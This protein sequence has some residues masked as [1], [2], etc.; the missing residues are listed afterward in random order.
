MKILSRLESGRFASILIL[1]AAVSAVLSLVTDESGL[2]VLF[3]GIAIIAIAVVLVAQIS[4]I[5]KISSIVNNNILKINQRVSIVAAETKDAIE[6]GADSSRALTTGQLREELKTA[7]EAH[8]ESLIGSNANL[9]DVQGV[10]DFP[11]NRFAPDS[12]VASKIIRRPQAHTAGRQATDM[13]LDGSSERNL[14]R[15]LC[16]QPDIDSRIIVGILEQPLLNDLVGLG[17][18]I[19]IVPYSVRN[20]PLVE[21]SY[22]IIDEGA[23]SNG[24]WAGALTTQRTDLLLELLDVVKNARGKG[25]ITIVVQSSV[26]QH[27]TGTLRKNV[28]VL[29]SE[30]AIVASDSQAHLL[31]ICVALFNIVKAGR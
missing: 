12:I 3:I 9:E 11:K 29:I 4:W 7:L 22:L 2:S 6:A 8:H 17:E 18:V 28:D 14:E 10:Q 31:P 21:A 15:L 30:K 25:I 19:E 1:L 23:L 20:T 16:R 26:P 27:F 24:C 5:R 13:A